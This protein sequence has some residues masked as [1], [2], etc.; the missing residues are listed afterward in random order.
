MVPKGKPMRHVFPLV[1]LL[2]SV[3]TLATDAIAQAYPS[4]PIRVIIP[5]G[6]SSPCDTLT[7]LIGQK[8]VERLGQGFIADIRTGAGGTIGLEIAAR[9]P[10][11]GYVIACGQGGNLVVVPH[12]YKK[13]PYDP[14]KD[15]A[16]VALLATNYLALAIHPSAPFKSVKE[17]IAYGKANPGK[18]SFASAGEGAFTHLTTERFR[19]QAGFTYL[20]V[21]YRTGYF[22]DLLSG[23]VDAVITAFTSMYPYVKS[24][25]LRVLAITKPTRAA[26]YPDIPTI[27]ETLPGFSAGA[28][29]GFIAPAATPA[30]VIT[31]LNREVNR[32]MGLPDV[33]ERMIALGLDI[34]TESPEFFGDTIR[35]DYAKYG[36]IVRAI[37]F[38]PQ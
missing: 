20:H 34:V 25:K 18:L 36:K 15:F 19:L 3:A 22:T 5:Y 1:V 35:S 9:M 10:P 17:L 13:L 23:Q 2:A 7:R 29:F 14:L 30:T 26:N 8:V 27:A 4:K 21:P 31:L 33:R 11:D 24:G 32:A 37:G 6:G 12:T 28:W 16:P 38:K